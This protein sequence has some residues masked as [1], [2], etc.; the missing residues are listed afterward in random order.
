M[1]VDFFYQLKAKAIPVSTSELLD[2][3]EVLKHL[4]AEPNPITVEQF[5]H[6]GRNCLIKHTKYYDDYDVVFAQVFHALLNDGDLKSQIEEWLKNSI[7]N[8]LSQQQKDNAL[9][10]PPE[11]LLEE[12]Q[13]RLKEQ[14]RRHDGGNRWIGTGGTSPF[15]NNGYNPNGIRVGGESSSRS[16]L[17]VAGKREFMD[18]RHDQILD[19]RQIKVALKKLRN[20]KKT[21]RPEISIDKSID[22][23]CKKGG[24]IHLVFEPKRKN[25]Y[26][27]LLLMDVG[28]SMT[29]YAKRVSQLFSASHQV[30]HFK[31]FHYYYFHNAIYDRLYHTAQMFDSQSINF[32][33][34]YQKHSRNTL[35]VM[36]GD[37][38]MAPYEMFS[39]N[40]SILSYYQQFQ[41]VPA[42]EKPKSAFERLK[43]IAQYFP[44]VVWLNPERQNFWKHETVN[45]V[46]SII[47]MF[48]LSLNGL[49]KA[50]NHLKHSA[51]TI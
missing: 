44:S 31:E 42:K 51:V 32:E 33:Q 12:F 35:V 20:L 19:I 17:A 15:G 48:Y 11:K 14:K 37:A 23:T 49:D 26:K 3:L 36:V 28:G 4:S 16:A 40:G 29:P 2:L 38:C 24:E 22:T 21:G 43:E 45:A 46:R 47:P 34:F 39:M 5:Y 25:Y 7:K 13:K 18:Y 1:F 50:I 27:L 30:N 6:I 10:I 9:F 8:Q 41:L